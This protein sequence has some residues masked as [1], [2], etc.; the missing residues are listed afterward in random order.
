MIL[1]SFRDAVEEDSLW[2]KESLLEEDVLCWFP[3]GDEREV[4]DAVRIWIGYN[5]L[6]S[7]FTALS[8]EGDICGMAT[9]YIQPFKKYRHQCLFSIVVG[10]KWRGQGIGKQIIEY[11]EHVAQT[12]FHI[13][14]LH[15]EVYEGNPAQR[16]YARMGFKTF[17][18]QPGFIKDRQGRYFAKNFMQKRL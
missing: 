2:L 1:C 7:A 18:K 5:R 6:G 16:L 3:M 17:G 15:L 14:I 12:K 10:K 9:L 4:E 8:P 13:E 11:L